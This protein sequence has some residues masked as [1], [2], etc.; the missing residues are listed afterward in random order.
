[1]QY[2]EHHCWHMMHNTIALSTPSSSALM[3]LAG[4]RF[5]A[6]KTY[7]P[8]YWRV[9]HQVKRLKAVRERIKDWKPIMQ[10]FVMRYVVLLTPSNMNLRQSPIKAEERKQQ[11]AEDTIVSCEAVTEQVSKPK[12]KRVS[13]FRY[14]LWD[15]QREE[16]KWEILDKD[17]H[18]KG[19]GGSNGLGLLMG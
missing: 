16:P 9:I 17:S 14:G 6:R 1:M 13:A 2:S 5:L 4:K 3:T 18:A 8:S 7:K 11:A 19:R 12:E 10:N 15:S